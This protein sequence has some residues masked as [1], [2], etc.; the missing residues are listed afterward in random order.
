[1]EIA[2]RVRS[3]YAI[4]N[5]R[6]WD[7]IARGLPEDFEAIDH[8]AV[9]ERHT[10]GPNALREIT[11]A[12]GDSVFA[13]MKMEPLEVE[14]VGDGSGVVWAVVRVGASASGG[15]SGAP[16]SGEVWQVWTY[17]ADVPKRF[18]QF[19]TREEARQATGLG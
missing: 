15:R 18:E 10:R 19:L 1:M 11:D 6:D 4:F 16:V 13:G 14:V 3:G 12:A 17:E 2:D 8:V 9:D 7:A 5:R